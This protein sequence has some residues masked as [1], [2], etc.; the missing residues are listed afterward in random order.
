MTMSCRAFYHDKTP[1][2][3]SVSHD[4]SRKVSLDMLRSLKYDTYFIDG[5]DYVSHSRK[6]ARE[7]GFLVPV[8]N[9]KVIWDFVGAE[10]TWNLSKS[11]KL[12]SNKPSK[13]IVSLDIL[14]VVV[15]GMHCVDIEDPISNSW[16]RIERGPGTVQ[17]IPSGSIVYFVPSIHKSIIFI[18]GIQSEYQVFR[19]DDAKLLALHRG[20]RKRIGLSS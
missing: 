18:K 7:Q 4:P 12:S 9:S 8:E 20:Y 19:D 15:S 10:N 13:Y 17:L 11:S 2:D 6:F 1:G 16:I 5:P 14:I 3:P